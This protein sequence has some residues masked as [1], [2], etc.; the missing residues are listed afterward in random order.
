MTT[1]YRTQAKTEAVVTLSAEEHAHLRWCEEMVHAL[2]HRVTL[3]CYTP[4]SPR[5]STN[6][7]IDDAWGLDFPAEVPLTEAIADA[8][9]MRP[10]YVSARVRPPEPPPWGQRAFGI[11]AI[12]A[13]SSVPLAVLGVF[14]LL[15]LV[16]T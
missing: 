11:A 3:V 13:L 15:F 12:A 10:P 8:L 14:Y 16:V 5:L 9:D 4:G 1:P 7:E 6:V 2:D